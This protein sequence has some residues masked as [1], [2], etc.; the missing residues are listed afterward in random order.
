MNT[1]NKITISRIILIAITLLSLFVLSFFKDLQ[2]PLLGNS[3]INLIFLIVACVFIIAAF[4]DFLDGYLARKN[5]EVTNLGKFLDPIA[6]K[7]LINSLVILLI[8][9]Q[10]FAPYN[11]E[12]VVSFNIWC[13]VLLIVRDV[14]VDAL[15]FIAA[16]KNVVIA[17][18]IFGKLKT[19]F[20]MVTISLILL[21]GFPFYYFDAS[22]YQGLH[23]TDFAVYITTAMSLISGIIYIVQNIKVFKDN[24]E[25][26]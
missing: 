13:G 25:K 23:I 11:H 19:V 1:P 3:G 14:I 18:N 20:E 24:K 5:N 6:D 8:A 4:T 9:P 21:N 26:E 16:S 15:R 2:T 10:F 12:Q 7:I 22:W 17:A